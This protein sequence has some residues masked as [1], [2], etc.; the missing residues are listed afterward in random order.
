LTQL[1]LGASSQWPVSSVQSAVAGFRTSGFWHLH[2]DLW[3]RLGPWC[4]GIFVV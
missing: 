3:L 4:L 1:V 2:P